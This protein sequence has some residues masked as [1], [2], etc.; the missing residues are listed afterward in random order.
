MIKKPTLEE[1]RVINIHVPGMEHVRCLSCMQLTWVWSLAP[2]L[3]F[4]FPLGVISESRIK[5]KSKEQLS[6]AQNKTKQNNTTM[7]IYN[8]HIYICVYI[9]IYIHKYIQW[10]YIYIYTHAPN[11]DQPKYIK[12]LLSDLKGIC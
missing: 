1:D 5:S 4:W 11:T 3:I 7:N 10:L 9:Y 8:I 2:H 6:I 12:Q